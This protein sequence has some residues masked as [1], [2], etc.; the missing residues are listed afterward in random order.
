MQGMMLGEPPDFGWIAEQ[1][2]VAEAALNA[3]GREARAG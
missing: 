3:P 2:R 1:I